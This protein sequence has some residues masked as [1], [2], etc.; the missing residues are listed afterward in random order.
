MNEVD[1]RHNLIA[2]QAEAIAGGRHEIGDTGFAGDDDHGLALAS[3]E[4]ETQFGPLRVAMRSFQPLRLWRASENPAMPE[5][6]ETYQ[7]LVPLAGTLN[8]L[9]D[10]RQATSGVGSLV[11]HDMSRL[12]ACEFRTRDLGTDFRTALVTV[13]RSLLPLPGGHI[14][15]MLGNRI[16]ACE[17]VGALLAGFVTNLARTPDAYRPSDGPRLGMVL[18]DLISALVA[19]TVDDSCKVPTHREALTLRIKAFIQQHLR[20]PDLTPRALAV[21]HNISTSYLHRLFQDQDTTVSGYVRAERLHRAR[22]DLADPALRDVPIHS[23]A[24]K[25]GF[26][27]AAEFSRA[28]RN[29]FGFPPRE[30]R[31][32]ALRT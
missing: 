6:R 26:S 30:F 18:L 10:D 12:V 16:A 32:E 29:A 2:P 13:P 5:D 24:A 15:R 22:R 11:V 27:Q 1:L 14:D 9:W 17:G 19:R 4:R 21:E 23:I 3:Y 7:L 28:F 20:E 25:W 31:R 8:A